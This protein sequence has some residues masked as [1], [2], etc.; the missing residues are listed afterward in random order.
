MYLKVAGNNRSC[1]VLDSF[2][3]AVD[4]Y[5]IPSRIHTDRGGENV[6]VVVYML[7]H[8]QR[9][10]GRNSVITGRSVHNQR[11]KRLW[12]DLFVGCLYFLEDIGLLDHTIVQICMLCTL[13]FCLLF[14]WTFFEMDGQITLSGLSITEHL[15]NSGQWAYTRCINR[16][17]N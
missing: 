14:S 13:C 4:E 15:F 11:I 12:R 5:G 1:T 7:Q 16:I 8:S 2:Q 6:L 10:T 3:S 9:G 17:P